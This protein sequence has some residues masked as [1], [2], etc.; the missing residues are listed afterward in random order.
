MS[1]PNQIE[2]FIF[3]DGSALD[4]IQITEQVIANQKTEGDDAVYGFINDNV[5]DGGAGNDF[6]SGVAGADTYVF[7]SGYGHDVVEDNDQSSKFFG[8]PYTDKIEFSDGLTWADFDYLR[9]GASDTLTIR[10]TGTDDQLTMVDFQKNVLGALVILTT[11]SRS[12]IS[13]TARCGRGSACC[14]ISS[15]TARP[16]AATWSMASARATRSAST[17]CST[18]GR[19]TTSCSDS[20]TTIATFSVAGPVK[21]PFSTPAAGTS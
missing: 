9:D 18:A 7:G 17:P 3:D 13:A 21:I 5:L 8:D 2:R 15:I 14:S 12:S 10:I 11:A 20:T 19:A 1:L 4:F 16:P 6:L